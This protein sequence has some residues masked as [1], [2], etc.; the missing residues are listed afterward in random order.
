MNHLAN[1]TEARL[2]SLTYRNKQKNWDW[3]QYTDAHM[4][5]HTIAKNL[6]EHGY[7]GL[8]K[9]SKVRHLL[10][11]I[12]DNA[13]QPVVCQVLAMR[14]EEKTFTTYSVLFADFFSNM[15]PV[16][17]LGSGGC[18][19]GR[20]RD[21]RGRSGGIRGR[22]GRGGRG[23][24][25]KRGPPDQSDVDKVTWLQA[26]KY[27]STKECAKFTAAEK[28]WIHQHCKSPQL[29]SAKL[30]L[31]VSRGDDSAAREL[32]DNGDLFGNHDNESVFSKHSIWLNSINPALVHQEKKTT[33]HK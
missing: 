24:P 32:D 27:Y 19:G 23:S 1:K 13:V 14:E 29:P 16:A 6:M 30:L 3:Y 12:Q 22:G 15:C 5:Q 31:P 26:N 8:G 11:G 10:T 20:G 4:K 18:G 17:K 7:S 33:C 21:A 2:A 25:S 9:R 28:Q